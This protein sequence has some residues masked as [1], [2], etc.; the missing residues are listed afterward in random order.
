[1]RNEN[2]FFLMYICLNSN[3]DPRQSNVVEDGE[4]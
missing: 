1:M 2:I 3:I 4:L